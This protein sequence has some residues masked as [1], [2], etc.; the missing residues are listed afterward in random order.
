M[1]STTVCPN[2]AK[3]IQ[4]RG[5]TSPFPSLVPLTFPARFGRKSLDTSA[6]DGSDSSFY[7]P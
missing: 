4:A 2:L 5:Q 6:V 7:R 3:S 1:N